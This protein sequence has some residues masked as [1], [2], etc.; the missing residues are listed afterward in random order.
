MNETSLQHHTK[1]TNTR[2]ELPTPTVLSS[3][4]I[5]VVGVDLCSVY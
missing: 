4:C 2:P 3:I 5:V 1:T